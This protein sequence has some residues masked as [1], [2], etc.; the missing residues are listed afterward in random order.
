MGIGSFSDLEKALFPNAVE[1]VPLEVFSGKRIA[2][3][4][5]LLCW[6]MFKKAADIIIKSTNVVTDQ[7]DYAAI[8]KFGIDKVIQKISTFLQYNITPVC[9]FDSKPH[10]LKQHAGNKQ[11][12][13]REK[14]LANFEEAKVELSHMDPILVS[15]KIID[16]YSSRLVSVMRPEHSF[17]QS[18]IIILKQLGIPVIM[19]AEMNLVTKDAEGI[20]ATL[21]MPG[22]DYCVATFT[23]DSDY[24]CY[25]GN[26]CITEIEGKKIGGKYRH[27]ATV[28]SLYK[29]LIECQMTFPMFV[30]LCIMMGTDFNSNMNN[31]GVK[32][33]TDLIRKFGSIDAIGQFG[34]DI[35]CLNHIAV[36]QMFAST[37]V[38]VEGVKCEIDRSLYIGV[39]DVLTEADLL[40]Y[41]S[42]FESFRF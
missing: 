30:D 14:D 34:R 36:R 8:E 11:A 31:C 17:M 9:V 7:V 33:N 26:V 16:T 25:G 27:F 32:R 22:N 1:Q 42:A 2:I 37:A 40:K 28:R 18:I 24:H 6:R 10:E 38:R 5:N 21:C 29:I 41:I 4:M 13:Q 3:D 19:T 39:R 20:C 15:R 35:S 12:D 23:T